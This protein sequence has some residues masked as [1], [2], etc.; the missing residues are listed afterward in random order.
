MSKLP[1][2]HHNTYYH[3]YNRG[4]NRETIFK[5][6]ENYHYFLKL[7]AKYIEP[8]A[9]TFAY[10]L[11][12]NHY[13]F[14]MRIKTEEEQQQ[15]H[16]TLKVSK[17]FKVL[18]PAQQFSNLFNAYTKAINKRYQRTGSLFENRYGR[19][20][21]DSDAYFTQLVAYI[22]QNP[23]KHGLIDD[24]RAWPYSSYQT[25]LSPHPTRLNREA[26]INWFSGIQQ[27]QTCHQLPVNEAGIE[28]LIIEDF[29]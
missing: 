24:F 8:V 15:T 16:Q 7:Y 12:P 2:L 6:K 11:L 14:L 5:E 3:I 26:V 28:P 22:H 29:D 4:N 9:E 25:L 18:K 17:T 21:V 1:P 20:P 10:C 23:Q 27:L 19:I 13:H